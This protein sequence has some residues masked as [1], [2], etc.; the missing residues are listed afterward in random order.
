[1]TMF[2]CPKCG[3]NYDDL[4]EVEWA[5][6]D[7]IRE[8]GQCSICHKEEYERTMGIKYEDFGSRAVI[9][10]K[11]IRLA[12]KLGY[13]TTGFHKMGRQQLYA[14]ARKLEGRCGK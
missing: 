6:C 9:K 3:R 2:I 13:R 4:D 14:I 8:T 5:E 7:E 11:V 10:R 12:K 1:M